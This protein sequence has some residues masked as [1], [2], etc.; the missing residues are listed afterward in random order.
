[1]AHSESLK[2]LYR[3]KISPT[4][5]A[6]LA[7]ADV[8]HMSLLEFTAGQI[9]QMLASKP[10]CRIH[11]KD[12][13][14]W[15]LRGYYPGTSVFFKLTLVKVD[16]SR[17]GDCTF[18]YFARLRALQVNP[19][20]GWGCSYGDFVVMSSSVSQAITEGMENTLLGADHKIKPVLEKVP[21][22]PKCM[23]PKGMKLFNYKKPRKKSAKT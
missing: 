20:K 22:K 16:N 2:D 10:N 14:I 19:R 11:G 5:I 18:S 21:G 4:L 9:Q 8:D 13:P 6:Q 1:M 12:K 23:A 15:I 7:V 17:Y 3:L